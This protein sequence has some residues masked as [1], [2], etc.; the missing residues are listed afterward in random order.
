[1]LLCYTLYLY[2]R[3]L[4]ITLRLNVIN[5]ENE[6]PDNR[7]QGI[8]YFWHQNIIA[9]MYFFYKKGGT[10][11]CVVSPSSDGKI[12]G[13]IAQKLGFKVLYGSAYKKSIKLVRQTLD[14]LEL[15]KLLCIVGDGSRGPAFKLQRGISYLAAKSQLP[16]I[17]V[18]CKSSSSLTFHNS[19]DKFQIPL[20]FSRISI[21]IKKPEYKRLETYKQKQH[22]T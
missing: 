17:F 5:D 22:E 11:H 12:A 21:R 6:A 10:G 3:L 18:G 13:F 14:V 19:W 16:L 15:N 1:M 8:Y 2:L 20:P 7:F 9:C 4:F